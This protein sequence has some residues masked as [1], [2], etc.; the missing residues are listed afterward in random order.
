[1]PLILNDQL[2]RKILK[3]R[4]PFEGRKLHQEL[5]Y[6]IKKVRFIF[7]TSWYYLLKYILL[8]PWQDLDCRPKNLQPPTLLSELP[9]F[10]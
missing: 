5:V 7:S 4:I 6:N 3:E 2:N 8:D 1:M 9:C 10:G